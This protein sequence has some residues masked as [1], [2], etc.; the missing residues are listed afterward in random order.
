MTHLQAVTVDKHLSHW[1][2]TIVDHFNFLRGYVFSLGQLENVL[3]YIDDLQC[4]ILQNI[5]EGGVG[6]H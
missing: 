4:A 6:C 1:I 2:T 5:G 3:L